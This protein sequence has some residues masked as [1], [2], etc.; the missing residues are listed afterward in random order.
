MYLE[1]SADKNVN[2]LG[3]KSDRNKVDWV[4][5]A[6][7]NPSYPKRT[8]RSAVLRMLKH[9]GEDSFLREGMGVWDT[10]GGFAV[11]PAAEWTTC[12]DLTSKIA[13]SPRFVLDVAP[14]RS[15]AAFAV[16][17]FREDGVPHVEITSRAG[18]VD[19]RPGVEWVVPRAVQ[20]KESFPGF[21]LWV[22]SG[23]SVEALV[24]ALVAAGVPLEFV[25][26]AD[27]PAAC[28][29]FYDYATTA[30]LRHIGQTE[31]T[32]ALAGARKNVEDGEGAW[33]WGWRKSS[34]DITTLYAATIALWVA[35]AGPAEVSFFSFNDLDDDEE[36]GDL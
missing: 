13:G 12:L 33:R 6:K 26:S 15:W 20:L 8:P 19:H 34:A 25:K 2:T 1:F 23:S 27:V 17:G 36:G 29:L 5:V 16:A 14:N 7:A 11:I 9:L 21:V 22:I 4:Q 31:L 30:G 35:I 10:D 3:W 28:G 18:V 32:D 24:P